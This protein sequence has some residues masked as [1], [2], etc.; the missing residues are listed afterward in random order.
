MAEE[1]PV[2]EEKPVEAAPAQKSSSSM[3]PKIVALLAWL[4]AP[5]T[6][7]IFLRSRGLADETYLC[8]KRT[9]RWDYVSG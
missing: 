2:V 7:I 6:S 3:D 9:N 1:K 8:I 5:L 4:F